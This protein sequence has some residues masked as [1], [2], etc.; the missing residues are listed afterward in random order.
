[1]RI[2]T[3]RAAKGQKL[4]YSNKGMISILIPSHFTNE[5]FEIYSLDGNLFEDIERFDTEKKAL[6][7]CK[8]L[9]D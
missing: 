7:R 4:A 6:D 8:E 9:L 3:G 2:T 5:M 1:M